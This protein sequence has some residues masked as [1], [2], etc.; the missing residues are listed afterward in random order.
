MEVKLYVG[1]LAYSTTENAIQQLFS[2][3]GTVTSVS[4]VK[5]RGSGQSKGFAFVTMATAAGAQ[6]AIAK[7]HDFSLAGRRLTVNIAEQS[8]APQSGY[9]SKLGAFSATGRSPT[10]NT[11]KPGKLGDGYQSK[12]GAFGNGSRPPTPPRRRGSNQR[13]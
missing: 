13:H 5:D 10:V 12:L 11:L 2:Q 7:L 9:Q 6:K 3:S 4:L 8:K 1:N